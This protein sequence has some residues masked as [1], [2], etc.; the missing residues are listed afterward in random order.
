MLA[1]IAVLALAAR[2]SITDFDSHVRAGTALIVEVLS[3]QSAERPRGQG[4][5]AAPLAEVEALLPGFGG[6]TPVALPDGAP[7]IGRNLAELDLRGEDRRV[8]ARDHARRRWHR[9]PVT[10]RAAAR[11]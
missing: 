11:R 2:R 5:H 7:A 6:V 8:G 4:H 9:E 3:R 10:A 1:A